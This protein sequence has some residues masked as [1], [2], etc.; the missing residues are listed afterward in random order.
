ML[1][2]QSK[3]GCGCVLVPKT[4]EQ[5]LYRH[6]NI[7][8]A[9]EQP[10]VIQHLHS[11]DRLN[12]SERKLADT[13][14]GYTS[15]SYVLSNRV[16][17][18]VKGGKLHRL[19]KKNSLDLASLVHTL[20]QRQPDTTQFGFVAKKRSKLLFSPETCIVAPPN[21]YAD[22][23]RRLSSKRKQLN[24]S[25]YRALVQ[26]LNKY[27][28]DIKKPG[29][30]DI[31]GYAKLAPLLIRQ[32]LR[33]AHYKSRL[34]SLL[35]SYLNTSYNFLSVI[36]HKDRL[37]GIKTGSQLQEMLDNEFFDE[38]RL[39]VQ[40]PGAPETARKLAK[41][42]GCHPVQL[43]HAPLGVVVG[44]KKDISRIMRLHAQRSLGS[45]SRAVA[46]QL[47]HATL[48]VDKGVYLPEVIAAFLN[49]K[50]A[51]AERLHSS[52][53]WNLTNIGAYEAQEH[54]RGEGSSIGIIDTGVD[55]DHP[56]LSARFEKNW[57][58]DF[59]DRDA[60]PYDKNEHGT[61]VA[62]TAAGDTIGVANA[63]RLYSLRVLDEVGRGRLSNV[64]EAVSWAVKHELD[65]I[66]L[67]LGSPSSSEIEYMVFKDAEEN[68]LLIAAAAGNEGYG[69]SYPAAYDCVMAVAAV[70]RDNEHA[71]FSNIWHTNSVSAPGV[72]VYS[73]IPNNGYAS[74][75]GTSM[76]SPHLAGAAALAR[77]LN[78]MDQNDF[79]EY[80]ESTAEPLGN[81][82]DPDNRS[83]FGAG[84]LRADRLVKEVIHG[85]E[86]GIYRG[87]REYAHN[88]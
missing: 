20:H 82:Q 41:E 55:R 24:D 49:R 72:S 74:L 61:H 81:P 80:L 32:E 13:L 12:L 40:G 23:K 30:Y 50:P 37:S 52:D 51:L 76:A 33:K 5:R 9:A 66:N 25:T 16:A 85:P 4:L 84:M 86:L 43:S 83:V 57:G 34:S 3:S 69:P 15:T 47:K 19:K 71:E 21:E 45:F 31:K 87:L 59:V 6:G 77:S 27:P 58:Y 26:L 65:V 88:R 14:S 75:S 54:T 67:S 35:Q 18:Q 22:R 62:G 56:Q 11:L 48:Y 1:I 38:H 7:V 10:D 28:R 78:F 8:V 60:Q 17:Y 2:S 68:G 73:S 44:D 64:L 53:M 63:S 29:P 36:F 79:I 46:N 39:I 70:D 42:T